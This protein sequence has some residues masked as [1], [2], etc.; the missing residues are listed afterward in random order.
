VLFPNIEDFVD[1]PAIGVFMARNPVSALLA[2]FY[3]CLYT[4]HENRRGGVVSCCV[5]LVW[6]MS[7]LP[8]KS[9]GTLE[10]LMVHKSF[11]VVVTSPMYPLWEVNDVLTT[12][13][14]SHSDSW[15]IG[16]PM[17]DEPDGHL[18]E[19]FILREGMEDPV[20]LRRI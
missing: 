13:L 4:K 18:L 10:I 8:K 1:F 5:P 6:L 15:G 16:Y 9:L 12:I 19:E 2:D 11:S 7:H 17:E 3:H 20:L 14:S